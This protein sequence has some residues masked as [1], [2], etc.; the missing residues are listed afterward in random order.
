[1]NRKREKL[2]VVDGGKGGRF[3]KIEMMTLG[4]VKLKRKKIEASLF[5][6][7][8]RSLYIFGVHLDF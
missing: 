7:F 2:T 1:M 6:L 5:L 3:T 8:I 4:G